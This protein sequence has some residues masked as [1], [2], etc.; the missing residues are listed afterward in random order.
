MTSYKGKL[1]LA[2]CVHCEEQRSVS[3][4]CS[5]SEQSHFHG[6][7]DLTYRAGSRF[8]MGLYTLHVECA[9]TTFFLT[10]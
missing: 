3:L 10:Q 8:R 4:T 1:L 7:G 5:L 9:V 6:L 2:N